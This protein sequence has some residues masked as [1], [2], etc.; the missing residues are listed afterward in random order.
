M[1]FAERVDVSVMED[2][3]RNLPI[4]EE[5]SPDVC[6]ETVWLQDCHLSGGFTYFGNYLKN[7]YGIDY[8]YAK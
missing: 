7:R 4:T 5:G 3:A 1:V 2:I 6:I 8:V